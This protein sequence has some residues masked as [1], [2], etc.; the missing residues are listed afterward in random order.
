MPRFHF[1]FL[2]GNRCITFEVRQE[3][4]PE[5][6]RSMGLT[7]YGHVKHAEATAALEVKATST[8]SE[9]SGITVTRYFLLHLHV[10][11]RT[12]L[13]SEYDLSIPQGPLTII[14]CLTFRGAVNHLVQ[15]VSHKSVADKELQRPM[16]IVSDLL[17]RHPSS[18][19][20]PCQT[21]PL[22]ILLDTTLY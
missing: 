7:K 20:P 5:E 3:V 22:F 1:C 14:P 6:R 4:P 19:D 16:W 8:T 9:Q 12:R 2:V 10:N 13:T 17:R 11:L 18:T 15:D 21:H